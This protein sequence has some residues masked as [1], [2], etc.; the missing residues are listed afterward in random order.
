MKEERNHKGVFSPPYGLK[1]V[2]SGGMSEGWGVGEL[3]YAAYGVL[4][5]LKFASELL[6]VIL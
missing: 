2:V 1:E 4:N 5:N 6:F 3:V